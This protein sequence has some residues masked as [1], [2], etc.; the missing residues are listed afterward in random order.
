MLR[1]TFFIEVDMFIETER[2]IIRDLKKSDAKAMYDYAKKSHIGPMAGWDPHTS[3]LETRKILLWMMK[4]KDVYAITLKPNDRLIGTIGL[5]E[6]NHQH[7]NKKVLEMGYVLDDI[8]WGQ[9][10]MPEAVKAIISY[11]FQTLKLDGINVG[12]K[13]SNTQSEKVILKTGFKH[14]HYETRRSHMNQ[15]Y[16]VK[17]YHKRREDYEQNI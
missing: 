14:T 7:K 17:M 16:I 15:E 8:Y 2:L 3:L 4:P 5:H 13:P 1:M 6:R 9:G 11:G 10:Y 12:H